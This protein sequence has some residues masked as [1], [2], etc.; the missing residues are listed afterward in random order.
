VLI[1]SARQCDP[2]AVHW[3]ANGGGHEIH[4]SYGFGAIDAGAAVWLAEGWVNVPHEVVVDTGVV[5]VGSPIPDNDP[6]GVS[7]TASI[8]DNIRIESVE[9]ILNAETTYV[10]DLRIAFTSPAGTTSVVAKQRVGDG[11]HNYEDYVFTSVRHWD[12]VSAGDW[13]VEI[14]DLAAGDLASWTDYRLIIYGTPICPGDLDEDGEI[15]MWDLFGLLSVYGTCEG[16]AG[17]EPA[18]DLI[19]NGCIDLSDLAQLLSVY[20]ESCE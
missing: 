5:T 18:A 6:N 19:N 13:T 14:A 1:E 8:A 7:V 17:F 2:N 12:E 10:G 4:Y 15:S 16:E 3:V 20:G 9:L 11:R